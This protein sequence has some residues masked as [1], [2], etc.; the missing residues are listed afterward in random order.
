MFKLFEKS[1][2]GLFSK[3]AVDEIF[4]LIPGSNFCYLF[5]K[6]GLFSSKIARNMLF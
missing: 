6:I 5:K 3:E 1:V 2:V 4:Y